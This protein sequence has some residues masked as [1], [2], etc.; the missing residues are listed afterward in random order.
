[1]RAEPEADRFAIFGE[2]RG[3]DDEIDLGLRFFAAPK[4]DLIV[5]EINPGAAFGDIVGAND[6]AEMHADFGGG[7]GHGEADEGGVFFEAAPVALVREGFAARDADRGEQTPAADQAGLSRR[8]AD[9]FDGQQA[10]VVKDVAMDQCRFL[11]LYSSEEC[12]CEGRAIGDES[13]AN[14]ESCLRELTPFG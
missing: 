3:I 8:Q 10:V 1:M 13:Y 14:V 7:V 11:M 12:G 9:F 2:G 5:N 6:F 4:T